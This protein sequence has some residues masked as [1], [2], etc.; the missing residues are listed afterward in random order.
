VI[1]NG[2]PVSRIFLIHSIIKVDGYSFRLVEV[3]L[4]LEGTLQYV[5]IRVSIG[6]TSIHSQTQLSGTSICKGWFTKVNCSTDVRLPTHFSLRPL[7]R[8]R[9]FSWISVQRA[10]V[11]VAITWLTNILQGAGYI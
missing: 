4:V 6:C 2:F 10:N 8:I 5:P 11:S 9:S 3:D 7:R 1:G